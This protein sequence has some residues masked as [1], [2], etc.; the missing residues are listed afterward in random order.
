LKGGT[1]GE[2]NLKKLDCKWERRAGFLGSGWAGYF[3]SG[4]AGFLKTW[5]AATMAGVE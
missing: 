3:E 4:W 2:H 5:R 1:E